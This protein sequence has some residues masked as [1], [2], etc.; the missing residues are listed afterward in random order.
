VGEDA[1]EHS[2]ADD[3]DGLLRGGPELLERQQRKI[4]ARQARG[5]E[6]A[7]EQDGAAVK[8]CATAGKGD[9]QHVHQGVGV[10]LR[11]VLA[12]SPPGGPRDDRRLLGLYVGHFINTGHNPVFSV[13]LVVL[14]GLWIPAAIKPV[15]RQEHGPRGRRSEALSRTVMTEG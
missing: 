10:H 11:V 3:G 5:S 7:H 8:A 2:H 6:P 4:P 13:L 1:D 12:G 14:I 9:G 15:R